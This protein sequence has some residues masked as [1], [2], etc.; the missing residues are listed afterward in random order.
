M[1]TQ[2][3]MWLPAPPADFCLRWGV[4]QADLLAVQYFLPVVP[5]T[6]VLLLLLLYSLAL[7][8]L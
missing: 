4:S 2:Q 1:Q 6:A 8:V 3:R 5:F 7:A